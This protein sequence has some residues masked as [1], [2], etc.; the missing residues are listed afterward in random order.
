MKYFIVFFFSSTITFGQLQLLQDP[1]QFG[2]PLQAN[3]GVEVEGNPYLYESWTSG[4]AS[5]S[6]DGVRFSFPKMR[7]NVLSERI[8]FENSGKVLF[9]DPALFSRFILIVG[10]DSLEFRNQNEGISDIPALA[11]ANIS[12][13]GKHQWI[14]KPTK[15]LINDPDAPYGSSKKKLIQSDNSFYLVKSKSE[16]LSFRMNARSIS[17][18]TGIPQK[19][20]ANGLQERNLSLENMAHFKMIFSWLDT[21]F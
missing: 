10:S 4:L 7:Y 6:K 18:A 20:I 1:T 16:I 12:F 17:K 15:T 19:I 11:Y 3:F 14:V 9:L 21:Q 5:M 13:S 2:K 8:E